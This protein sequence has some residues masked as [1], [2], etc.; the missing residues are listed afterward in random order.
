MQESRIARGG[1]SER[2]V[3]AGGIVIPM[4]SV[5]ESPADLYRWSLMLDRSH[6]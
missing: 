5:A 1:I 6:I 3:A 2:G 4:V